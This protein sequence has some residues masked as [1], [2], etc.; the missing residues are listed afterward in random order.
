[1]KVILRVLR[2]LEGSLSWLQVV[3]YGTESGRVWICA[4]VPIVAK[5]I[6]LFRTLVTRMSIILSRDAY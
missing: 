1:M 4:Q 2:M 3:S 6:V 5:G